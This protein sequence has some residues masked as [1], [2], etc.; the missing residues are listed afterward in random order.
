MSKSYTGGCACGLISYE[1]QG[2]PVLMA[3]CQC[4]QCQRDSG[5]GHASHVVFK[6][7]NVSVHGE[8]KVWNCR[9]DNGTIK[10]NGFC[11]VCGAPVFTMFPEMPEFFSVR[12]ASLDEPSRYQP[13]LV[14]WTATGHAWDVLDPSLPSY[15]RMQPGAL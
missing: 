14:L 3:D 9:G 2:Q 10:G 7:A 12:A 11:A 13:Q 5:T 6:D 4:R 15:E 1:I 8:A